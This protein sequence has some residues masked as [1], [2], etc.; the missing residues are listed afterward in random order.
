MREDQEPCPG[1]GRG[2]TVRQAEDAGTLELECNFYTAM[3]TPTDSCPETGRMK[4]RAWFIG[5][6]VV[7]LGTLAVI[8]AVV[9]AR[10]EEFRTSRMDIETDWSEIDLVFRGQSI[11]TSLHDV[12]E[13]LASGEGTVDAESARKLLAE[14]ETVCRRLRKRASE[15][16]EG[17]NVSEDELGAVGELGRSLAAARAAV[18]AGRFGDA[19]EE[20]GR[21][22]A[23]L[24]K[25][26][27]G[28]RE[29]V[30]EALREMRGHEHAL[31]KTVMYGFAVV[32][33]LFAAG[34]GALAWSVIRPIAALT[35]NAQRVRDHEFDIPP[36]PAS[37]G[38]IA[39][40]E[41]AFVDMAR[42]LRS[43]TGE[44]ER[45]VAERTSELEQSRAQ[46]R[47][48]LDRLPDA[49]GLL[50]ED[51][52]VL[53]ANGA[54]KRL[55]GEVRQPPNRDSMERTVQGYRRWTAPDGATR[56]LD[57]RRYPMGDSGLLTLEHARDMTRVSEAEAALAATQQLAAIGGLSTAVAHEINNPLT[58]IGA[59]AEGL[60]ER[61]R[62]EDAGGVQREYLELI[63]GEVYRCKRVTGRLLEVFRGESHPVERGSVGR[64]AEECL[65]L[66][67]PLADGKEITTSLETTGD[68]N[69]ETN[70]DAVRQ[71]VLNLLMNATQACNRG[72]QIA[73]KVAGSPDAVRVRVE[74]NGRGIAPEDFERLFEPLFTARRESGGTGIGLFIGR[75][76]ARALGGHIAAESEGEG[77]GAAFIVTIPRSNALEEEHP[78]Q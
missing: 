28:A 30:D 72:G 3:T 44:L 16:A 27:T 68:D 53:A 46:L 76:L 29:E 35:E 8:V 54:Y 6:S 9:M 42:E 15:G 40:L 17:M 21:G 33:V 20:C 75:S 70:L 73:V 55:F 38:E 1:C 62:A 74:D 11:L 52:T 60:L 4:L 12:L 49:V 50:Q 66:A 43:F 39:V 18:D 67:G 48:M 34:W 13:G 26:I 69:V 24:G 78:S 22:L 19:E 61:L 63:V 65:R 47:F 36:M 57:L 10:R 58:A 25:F 23:A 59:C 56:L 2:F 51:G 77:K 37:I 41:Q 14:A 32:A 7:L 45:R 71:I 31:E 5:F 64:I